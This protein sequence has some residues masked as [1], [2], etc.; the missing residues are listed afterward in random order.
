MKI[1][2]QCHCGEL[3]YEAEVDPRQASICHC[4]DCQILTGTAYRVSVPAKAEDFR[5]FR[6]DDGS[7]ARTAVAR[8]I[9]YRSSPP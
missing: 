7:A 1:H 2:G 5:I 8:T 6:G 3:V 9:T 4:V